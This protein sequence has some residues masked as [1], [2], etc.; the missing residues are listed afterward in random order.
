MKSAA[1]I[2]EVRESTQALWDSHQRYIATNGQLGLRCFS[3]EVLEEKMK[4]TDREIIEQG[5][6][7]GVYIEDA[8]EYLAS[9]K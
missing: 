6:E 3:P 2:K 8:N 4:R 9:L 7:R 5:L 1:L